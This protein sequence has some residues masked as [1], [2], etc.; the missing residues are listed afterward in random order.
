MLIVLFASFAAGCQRLRWWHMAGALAGLVGTALLIIPAAGLTFPA[1]YAVGYGAAFRLRRDVGR[2]FS[3]EPS[4]CARTDGSSGGVLGATA[5][6]A[7][8]SH[9][10]FEPTVWPRG[11][12]WLAV[13]TMG[14]GPGAPLS[15]PVIWREA[16]RHPR[17]RRLRLLHSA[18]VDD[19][20]RRLR[21]SRAELG[22]R[23]RRAA[24]RRR[25][26]AALA[27][28][29]QRSARSRPTCRTKASDRTLR[30]SPDISPGAG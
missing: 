3:D 26:W 6:L 8:L 1:E 24:D 10:V 18:A 14:L 23:R 12:E 19:A 28:L 11:G 17:A 15:S 21:A 29:D 4:L 22:S 2:L 13:L 30:P 9:L 25:C 20:P 27:S 5:V 7:A 16:G